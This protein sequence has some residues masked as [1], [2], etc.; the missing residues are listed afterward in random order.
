[1][2]TLS[3]FLIEA[4]VGNYV[5]IDAVLPINLKNDIDSLNLSVPRISDEKLHATLIYSIGT[6]VDEDRIGKLLAHQPEQFHG[7]I[8]HATKFD[9]L[10][11]EGKRPSGL[12][13]IVL[14]I[15]SPE[16]VRLHNTLKV[17]GLTHSYDEYK[18]H[19][20]L[21]YNI[22]IEEAEETLDKIN[23]ISK[24]RHVIFAGYRVEPL[25]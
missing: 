4:K 7:T 12:C 18:P 24:N 5:A 13:T 25:K 16:L 23:H 10:P 9:A 21:F 22:P 1:M 20:S 11:K 14:E 17:L 19:V 8:T 2:M 6:T 15:E 3:E